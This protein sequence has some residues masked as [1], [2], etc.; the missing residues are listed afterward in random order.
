MNGFVTDA[1]YALR[2]LRRSPGF[3]A[4]AVGILALGIGATT[5]VFSVIDSVFFQPLP[6]DGAGALVRLRD[7]RT[8]ADGRREEFNTSAASFEA[9][10]EQSRVFD[11]LGAFV[12]GSA[13]VSNGDLPERVS[14]VGVTGGLGATL[15][16]PV[17]AGRDFREEEIRRG[18]DSGSRRRPESIPSCSSTGRPTR[19]WAFSQ[20][21]FDSPTRRTSGFPR[22]CVRAT[23]R[24]SS[25]NSSPG[26]RSRGP[27]PSSRRSP[28]GVGRR[29]SRRAPV[30]A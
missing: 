8:A 15:G 14:V 23:T 28:R 26:F 11:R 18:R 17:R 6:I 9:I 16:V 13:A 29:D 5:A 20:K 22:A 4:A 7:F 12:Y 19:S 30:S 2:S 27:T 3:S 25:R 24:R 21:G 1:R 10:R